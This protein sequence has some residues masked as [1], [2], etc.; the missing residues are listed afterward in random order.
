[1]EAVVNK[2]NYNVN[3]GLINDVPKVDLK[4]KFKDSIN[5]NSKNNVNNTGENDIKLA[6]N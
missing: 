2:F 5:L 6:E 1:M 4:K 3:L